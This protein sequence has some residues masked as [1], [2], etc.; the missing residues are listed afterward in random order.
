M[1]YIAC[2]SV[3]ILEHSFT[4]LSF[5]M[6]SFTPFHHV[7]DPAAMVLIFSSALFRCSSTS[8]DLNIVDKYFHKGDFFLNAAFFAQR[9]LFIRGVLMGFLP[10]GV[11]TDLIGQYLLTI[12][13]SLSCRILAFSLGSWLFNFHQFAI[14]SV[15]TFYS[16]GARG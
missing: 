16:R 2:H 4:R 12:F 11:R 3:D 14:L 10:T 15:T 9:N 6:T 1:L 5:V 7:F 8:F 13:I